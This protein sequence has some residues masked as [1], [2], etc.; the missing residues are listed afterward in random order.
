MPGRT[1]IATRRL[2]EAGGLALVCILTSAA[3]EEVCG[4]P[5]QPPEVDGTIS[6][7]VFTPDSVPVPNAEIEAD[8]GVG[9]CTQ[10]DERLDTHGSADATGRYLVQVLS[11]DRIENVCLRVRA[12]PSGISLLNA[13]D[14]VEL[15]VTENAYGELSAH[16]EH[17]LY[18]KPAD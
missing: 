15:T 11:Y 10:P 18:L 4:C 2:I 7:F 8:A 6:G 17:D 14:F 3:C 13:S 1:G 5:P 12:M 9:S 16:L